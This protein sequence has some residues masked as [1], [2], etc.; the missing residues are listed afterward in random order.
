MIARKQQI[1]LQLNQLIDTLLLGGVFWL[2]HFLRSAKLAALDSLE[3]VPG[4]EEADVGW[5]ILTFSGIELDKVRQAGEVCEVEGGAGLA[6]RRLYSYLGGAAHIREPWQAAHA[7]FPNHS[8][9]LLGTHCQERDR[10]LRRRDGPDRAY[11]SARQCLPF[12][13]M[14]LVGP[15]PLPLY[16]AEEFTNATAMC[17]TP[18]SCLLQ[19]AVHIS[20]KTH[21]LP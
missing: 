15:R 17:A 13:D 3:S 18:F 21:A 16:E 4:F 14:S 2:C 1:S 7:R 8:G 12:G 6:E 10:L 19:K 9:S 11:T 20:L 5:V